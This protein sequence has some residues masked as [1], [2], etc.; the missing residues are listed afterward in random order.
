MSSINSRFLF[1]TFLFSA[2]L[3][4]MEP[5]LPKQ[6]HKKRMIPSLQFLSALTILKHTIPY[7]TCVSVSLQEYIGKLARYCL[8]PDTKFLIQKA[9][10]EDNHALIPDLVAWGAHVNDSFTHDYDGTSSNAILTAVQEGKHKAVRI[11]L[12]YDVDLSENVSICGCESYSCLDHNLNPMQLALRRR[13]SG[14]VQIFLEN[15]I[16]LYDKHDPSENSWYQA[17][18]EEFPELLRKLIE[19]QKKKI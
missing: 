17:A 3:F 8:G 11:L 15:G 7:K 18:S 10:R 19:E 16:A 5:S 6:P 2:R 1:W 14:C 9:V 12:Q 13:D 4:N